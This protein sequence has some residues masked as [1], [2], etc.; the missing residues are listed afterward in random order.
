MISDK[1][2]QQ[3]TERMEKLPGAIDAIGNAASNLT[4]DSGTAEAIERLF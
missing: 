4:G 3:T 2:T 1:A